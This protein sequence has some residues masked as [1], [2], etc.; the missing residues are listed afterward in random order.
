MLHGPAPFS[1]GSPSEFPAIC[2]RGAGYRCE[3][4]CVQANATSAQSRSPRSRPG[5]CAGRRCRRRGRGVSQPAAA[6]APTAAVRPRA[7]SSRRISPRRRA[8]TA[9]Q[10]RSRSRGRHPPQHLFSQGDVDDQTIEVADQEE[11]GGGSPACRP[12]RFAGRRGRRSASAPP[13]AERRAPLLGGGPRLRHP[14]RGLLGLRFGHPELRLLGLE[15][16][17][18]HQVLGGEPHQRLPLADRVPALRQH[19]DDRRLDLRPDRHLVLR[20]HRAVELA[21]QRQR[22]LPRRHRLH[23]RRHPVLPP[24]VLLPAAP[25]QQAA[26][27]TENRERTER[28]TADATRSHHIRPSLQAAPLGQSPTPTPLSSRPE[29]RAQP[30]ATPPCR[31]DRK[32]GRQPELE[33]RDLGGEPRR[34]RLLPEE[35]WPRY[36]GDSENSP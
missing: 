33:W 17:V 9:D 15:V 8:G 22:P 5:P 24:A 29:A 16:E 26:G 19:R 4:R 25:G 6:A 35:L 14:R 36:Y 7:S 13:L 12:R 1:G 11:G 30:L 34:S 27:E 21:R 20:P 28:P 3:A 10:A 23:R 31:L 2:R 18:A 32:L